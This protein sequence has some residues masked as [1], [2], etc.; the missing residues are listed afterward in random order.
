MMLLPLSTLSVA[1][2]D[3]KDLLHRLTTN[4]VLK[5]NVGDVFPNVFTSEK[6][7]VLELTTMVIR[8]DDVLVLGQAPAAALARWIAKMTFR[9]KVQVRDLGLHVVS[10]LEGPIAG[11]VFAL[12]GK[13]AGVVA[14]HGLVQEAPAAVDDFEH[15]RIAR[16]IPWL[17]KDVGDDNNPH[18]A[19]L[20]DAISWDK[21]CY[22][23]QEVVARLDTYDK[24]QRHL[25]ML[26]PRAA[27]AVGAR[28]RLGDDDVGHV[29]S[30]SEHGGEVVALGYVHK[31][32]GDARELS[33]SGVAVSLLAAAAP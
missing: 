17:G 32:A 4:E 8:D 3:A 15:W 28:L 18:E 27:L 2:K 5:R 30:V 16:G 6:G 21:G 19:G 9:E 29:T 26:R 1:G 13:V 31:R 20:A 11:A 33:S 10:S 14:H 23:G 7:R 25:R 22:I 24:V 12:Q